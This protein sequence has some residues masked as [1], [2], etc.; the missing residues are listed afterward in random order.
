MID[1]DTLWRKVR[2]AN[3]LVHTIS[4]LVSANDCAN[5]LLAVG[6][7]PIMA[8]AIQEMEDITRI[9]QATVLNLGTPSDT[10]YATCTKAGVNAN[11]FAHPVI[12]DPVG[13]GASRYRKEKITELLHHVQPT[14]I[15]AN[16]GEI[17]SLLGSKSQARGVDSFGQ[18]TTDGQSDAVL[19]AR[20]LN[21]VVL[22]TG[23]S[24]FITDG[25]RSYLIKGGSSLLTRL[26]GTGDMLSVLCGA[27]SYI[28]DPLTAATCASFTWKI[29]GELVNDT[30]SGL[31]Q[32]HMQ[33]F[34][35]A[36][37][38]EQLTNKNHNVS[39]EEVGGKTHDD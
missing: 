6:A 19:L 35:Y 11:A 25:M 13:V 26:T 38:M 9:S 8:S 17:Q 21:C 37:Q 14:I 7:S 18:N 32:A 34:D 23:P 39:I 33:L 20:Q 15:R 12:I 10:K 31:G 30:A 29:I 22:M 28:T 24:D 1:I 2:E 16:V 3:P 4:N 36:S 27:L 5:L